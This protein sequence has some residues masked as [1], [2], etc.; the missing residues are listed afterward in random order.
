VRKQ[1]DC[2]SALTEQSCNTSSKIGVCPR[3]V[4]LNRKGK[5]ARVPVR[6]YNMSAKA[7]TIAP[8]SLLCDLQEVKVL[9]SITPLDRENSTAI[10]GQ[11]VV[12][13]NPDDKIC[14]ESEFRLSD[15]GVDLSDSVLS[16]D[17]KA[18]A[19]LI[20]QKW[21]SVFSRGLLDL[22]HT[23]LVKHTIKLTDDTPFK[24]AYRRISPAMIEEVREHIAEMLAANTIRPSSSPFSSNVVIVRKKDGTI[25]LCIDFRKLNQRTIKDAYGIP[26]IEDSL[27]LLVGSKF[28]TK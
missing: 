22:G 20:F 11:H 27:H 12:T 28:F 16:E 18:K 21:Q 26:R 15:I 5:T 14:T 10:S 2:D 8:R 1:G 19:S 9:R 3:V 24:E 13:E 4:K 17:Q 23:D 25:R 6:L 7:I